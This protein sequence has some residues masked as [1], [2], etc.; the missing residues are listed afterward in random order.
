[1]GNAPIILVGTKMDKDRNV[2]FD[3]GERVATIHKSPYIEC[4]SYT[5]ENID[6]VFELL[7]RELRKKDHRGSE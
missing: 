7:V 5:G 6:D 3:L 2:N 4:S 1:M